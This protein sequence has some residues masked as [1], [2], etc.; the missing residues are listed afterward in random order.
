MNENEKEN[1]IPKLKE[2]GNQ[3]FKAKDYIGAAD[4]Y[5]EAIGMLEQLLLKCVYILLCIKKIMTLILY[6]IIELQ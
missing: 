4:K 3:L 6:K 2:E 1:A 5:A